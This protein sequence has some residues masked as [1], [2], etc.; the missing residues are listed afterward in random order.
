MLSLVSTL[1]ILESVSGTQFACILKEWLIMILMIGVCK[2]HK[3]RGLNLEFW[4]MSAHGFYL[5]FTV[6]FYFTVI[7]R[8]LLV[9]VTSPA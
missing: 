8:H 1:R 7:F 2:Q 5:M 4:V 6:F 9:K 3:D